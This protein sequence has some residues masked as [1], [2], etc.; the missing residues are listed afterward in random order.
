MSPS[1]P[2][3]P[4]PISN[5]PGLG[6][7]SSSFAHSRTPH[8]EFGV[9]I[10]ETR[11]SL[12]S[13]PRQPIV[14]DHL[15]RPSTL[16]TLAHSPAPYLEFG[17]PV[18]ETLKSS[19]ST[20]RQP[21]AQEHSTRP[22]TLPS[23]NSLPSPQPG[24]HLTRIGRPTE[25]LQAYSQDRP[26]GLFLGE[27]PIFPFKVRLPPLPAARRNSGQSSAGQGTTSGDV[28]AS[29]TYRVTSGDSRRPSRM[30]NRPPM[31]TVL[32]RNGPQCRKFVEGLILQQPRLRRLD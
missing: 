26:P 13:T 1:S 24:A 9:T 28:M 20:P 32:C 11:V 29:Q 17:V 18:A 23:L 12:P 30:E 4:S 19:P 7:E 15:T 27:P 3:L 22:S 14:Q 10:T 2:A 5:L 25:S 21:T 6:Q 16:P 31:S 8:L